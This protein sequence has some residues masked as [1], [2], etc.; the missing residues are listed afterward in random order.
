MKPS[1]SM[2]YILSSFVVN[3]FFLYSALSFACVFPFIV[4]FCIVFLELGIA[5]IQAYV[6]TCLSMVYISLASAHHDHDEHH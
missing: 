6:F 1:R 5:C 4:V 2:L 3:M